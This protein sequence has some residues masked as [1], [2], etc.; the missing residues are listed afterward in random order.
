ML[1]KSKLAV[2]LVSLTL[3]GACRA[4][5]DA[6]VQVNDPNDLEPSPTPTATATPMPSATPTAMPSP[7]ASPTSSPTA[8][9][10]PSASPTATPTATPTPGW[11]TIIIQATADAYASF[12]AEVRRLE[13]QS[14]VVNVQILA[15]F[16]IQLTASATVITQLQEVARTEPV[17]F[18]PLLQIS[19]N[20]PFTFTRAI[21]SAQELID[22][23]RQYLPGQPLPGIDFSHSTVLAIFGGPQSS[24]S[25]SSVL[26]VKKTDKLLKV[27][28][29][30]STTSSTTN[31]VNPVQI[32]VVPKSMLTGEITSVAFEQ[33][34]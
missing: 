26:S 19:I 32:V 7:S 22:F 12:L 27:T 28:Y 31:G 23:Y 29:K 20:S 2:L 15:D 9:P 11:S 17:S 1:R 24:S 16:R 25:F 21:G 14:M 6:P 3:V 8:T 10:S 30:V 18:Q 5:I 4:K 33:S 34:N 13:S